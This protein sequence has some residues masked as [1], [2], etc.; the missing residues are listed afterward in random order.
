MRLRLIML[1]VIG[2]LFGLVGA[3]TYLEVSAQRSIH[4][5]AIKAVAK[6]VEEGVLG[7]LIHELQKERGYSAGFLSSKGAVFKTNVPEQRALTD[8][9]IAAVNEQVQL[10]RQERAGLFGEIETALSQLSEMRL[11][12]DGIAVK[13][14]EMAGFYTSMINDL[15]ALSRDTI[16]ITGSS[17]FPALQQTRFL[18]SAVKE[19]AG[20][21]R[22]MG[23]VGIGRG[24]DLALHDRFVSLSG[25]QQSML[26]EAGRS[27]KEP[28]WLTNLQ[29]SN[30]YQTLEALRERM[31]LAYADKDVSKLSGPQWFATSTQWIE[32]LRKQEVALSE[33]VVSYAKEVE[34]RSYTALMQVMGWSA[35]AS[36]IAVAFALFC[37]EAMIRRIKALTAAVHAFASGDFDVTIEGLER[38]DELSRMALAIQTFKDESLAMRTSALRLEAEQKDREAAQNEVM[39]TLSDQLASLSNGDLSV[40]IGA[41]FPESYEQLRK[42]FNNTVSSLN[43]AFMTIADTSDSIRNGAAE[44]SQ[45]SGDLSYRTESQA[46]TLEQTAAALEELTASVRSSADG[47][48]RV[49]TTMSETRAEA[50]MSGEV[51]Q[52]AVAAMTEIESSSNHISKIITVID[53]I[54]FQTNLLAL[55]AGVEAARAGD[56]GRGFAVVASEVRALAQRSS[57]AAMEIKTL[58]EESSQHVDR[59]VNQVGKAGGALTK[60]VD[61]IN[62]VSELISGI[63]E[64]AS[65]QSTGLNEIN[66]GVSQLDQVTQQNAAMVEEA[67]AASQLLDGD[68]RK[69]AELISGFRFDQTFAD[70]A[71][72]PTLADEV[73]EPSLRSA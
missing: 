40:K 18:V 37:F 66:I 7:D 48:R 42:D 17:D 4:S 25:A 43:A 60:I 41:Q 50:E 35:V 23:A 29:A 5:K 70:A 2:P 56:A 27:L 12:V 10:I 72:E 20:L 24:F 13:V 65:E 62:H 39:Q 3:F 44:I 36:L 49:E 31:I 34:Q 53:D 21:E 22:A 71:T 32:L 26:S 68:A 8:Q 63:A 28:Q 14:P 64:G 69:L 51:V 47:A 59:G 55:N 11:N 67:T 16:A 73:A 30:E 9:A 33:R 54:A 46:A 52:G 38:K 57:D 19:L 15:L 45:S 61:R 1:L 58:I 6:T